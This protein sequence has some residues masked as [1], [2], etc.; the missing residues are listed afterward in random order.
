MPCR[1]QLLRS[2]CP[3]GRRT[4][5]SRRKGP[6][7][8]LQ[9]EHG[10]RASVLVAPGTWPLPVLVPSVQG[11]VRLVVDAQQVAPLKNGI[12]WTVEGSVSYVVLPGGI[13]AD[14][15]RRDEKF[16]PVDE[17]A[18][19]TSVFCLLERLPE[20]LFLLQCFRQ[21]IPALAL[22]LLDYLVKLFLRFVPP[23]DHVHDG[24]VL[25]GCV[26]IPLP[27]LLVP[28]LSPLPPALHDC[29][30]GE[31]EVVAFRHLQLLFSPPFLSFPP[32]LPWWAHIAGALSRR[33]SFFQLGYIV[34]RMLPFDEFYVDSVRP[35]RGGDG[36]LIGTILPHPSNFIPEPHLLC[37]GPSF[38]RVGKHVLECLVQAALLL[39]VLL[40]RCVVFF[41]QARPLQGLKDGFT[42]DI[43]DRNLSSQLIL[44]DECFQGIVVSRLV[45]G[46]DA[47]L[48]CPAHN[49]I[50]VVVQVEIVVAEIVISVAQTGST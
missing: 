44:L 3:P 5:R 43:L 35:I 39:R 29:S 37:V 15:L 17:V 46:L 2:P 27:F 8:E 30:I 1:W 49:I 21:W 24:V 45:S 9:R 38:V 40:A 23:N 32:R 36:D 16:V 34:V 31:T 22:Q 7:H 47:G 13:R 20:F 50:N 11:V 18:E 25:L 4:S 41:R 26:A 42:T 6:V 12:G 48:G 19:T 33:R 10:L 14:G 28:V